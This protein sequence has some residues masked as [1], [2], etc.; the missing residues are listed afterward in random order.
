MGK[1]VR[2]QTE[3]NEH[4]HARKRVETVDTHEFSPVHVVHIQCIQSPTFG[5]FF[6]A[7]VLTAYL[8]HRL[9]DLLLLATTPTAD[10]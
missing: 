8:I 10:G 7:D 6:T 5:Q 2:F 1:E 4:T 9:R 3:K